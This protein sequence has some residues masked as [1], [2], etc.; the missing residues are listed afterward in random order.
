[1][2]RR[3]QER[4]PTKA[5]E[6]VGIPEQV[7]DEMVFRPDQEITD[8]D[9]KRMF[10][11]V[12]GLMA[13]NRIAIGSTIGELV[14]AMTLV[15]PSRVT[16]LRSYLDTLPQADGFYT[17]MKN[18]LE[19]LISQDTGIIDVLPLSYRGRYGA[20]Y[21]QAIRALYP[22]HHD[23]DEV[24]ERFIAFFKRAEDEIA[25][26]RPEEEY[27]AYAAYCRTVGPEVF[28]QINIDDALWSRAITLFRSEHHVNDAV[29]L[30]GELAVLFPE[31]AAEIKLSPNIFNAAMEEFEEDRLNSRWEAFMTV[32]SQ[33]SIIS[34]E[35]L[36][37][38][39]SGELKLQYPSKSTNQSPSLPE[40]AQV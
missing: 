12:G 36:H 20:K 35:R 39:D 34:A 4:T 16:R 10:E 7:P 38:T 2:K 29:G 9:W 6:V 24:P 17:V 22:E 11:S 33:L 14:Y 23:Y 3:P 28:Q 26:M 25:S 15:D 37:I 13:Q 18:Q 32:A 8:E 1:M 31:R 27:I 19:S 40:R 30:G 5:T 21:I